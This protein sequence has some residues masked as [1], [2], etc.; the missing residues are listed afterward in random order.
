MAQTKPKQSP[1]YR[2]RVCELMNRHL[3]ERGW[4][5]A[6][7]ANESGQSKATISR[8]TNFGSK[9]SEY[10]RPSMQTVQAVSLALRL[11]PEERRELFYT[12]FPEFAVWDEASEKGCSVSDTDE[13]LFDRKLPLLTKA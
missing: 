5:P 7:L 6:K 3:N 13:L 8:L 12:I 10:Y 1:D 4:S 9:L 11:D 2:N